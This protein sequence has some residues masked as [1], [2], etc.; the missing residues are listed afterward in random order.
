[1]AQPAG[2]ERTRPVETKVRLINAIDEALIER[3]LL[4]PKSLRSFETPAVVDLSALYLMLPESVVRRL[5]LRLMGQKRVRLADGREE[6]VGVTEALRIEWQGQF[7]SEDALVRGEQV[8]IGQIVA[9][10]LDLRLGYPEP[11]GSEPPTPHAG[12]TVSPAPFRFGYS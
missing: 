6:T 11:S 5:G 4:S 10:K 12:D 7:T 8:V 2:T 1:M 3:E 9:Q